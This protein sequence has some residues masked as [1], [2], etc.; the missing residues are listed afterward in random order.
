MRL[1]LC[2]R[3]DE[4]SVQS[5]V[6]GLPQRRPGAIAII[7]RQRIH[8]VNA[9][10]S[11][12]GLE[13][14]MDLR[15]ARAIT[16]DEPLQVLERD[17]AAETRALEALCCWAYGITPDLCSWR[18]DCL[19]LEVGGSLRLFGGIE[20]I[21]RHC[22]RGLACRGYTAAKGLASTAL[23]AWALSFE[24]DALALDTQRPLPERL[25]T[26]PLQRLSALEPA[27]DA[28]QRSGLQQLGQLLD[29]PAA[30][31]R[32]R[33]GHDAAIIL[34]QLLSASDPLEA[35]FS[36]PA[37]FFDSHP[38]GY[39]LSDYQELTPALEALLQSLQAYLRQRQLQTRT[40]TWHFIGYGS[41]REILE[42]SASSEHNQWQDWL[43]LTRLRLEQQPF[44][45]AVEIVQLRCEGLENTT[46]DSGSLFA[47]PGQREPRERIVDVLSTRLGPQCVSHLHC[48]DAHL[49]EHSCAVASAV[50]TPQ[51]P[52][53][54]PV[55]AQRPFWL[56]PAPE[57]LRESNGR[58]MY[59]GNPL[60]SVYGPE[61]IEDGWW[62][63]P[64]SRDYFVA[65]NPQGQRF[66]IFFERRQQQWFLHGIFP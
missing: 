37:C 9:A 16:G 4:L 42:L 65:Q 59:W 53:A 63:K 44:R 60:T 54:E 28:L 12:L 27:F 11:L 21:L 41:Y 5:L 3:L 36:P 64:V 35:I 20:A 66:W 26:V 33:C 32:K 14:A 31:L 17:R 25:A 62:D 50:E 18:G 34:E 8:A 38:L 7:E 39:A 24:D 40:I 1:W 29:L 2:L 58:L 23:A 13:P 22:D 57:L 46:A 49:P 55:S 19:L 15:S 47:D 61:R 6:Q 52:P 56:L 51:A 30:A 45:E 48:R 43:R 10:A